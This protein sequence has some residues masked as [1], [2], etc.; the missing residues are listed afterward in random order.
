MKADMTPPALKAMIDP[1]HLLKAIE[2]SVSHSSDTSHGTT[3]L[4][5]E[6]YSI[7]VRRKKGLCWLIECKPRPAEREA[8]GPKRREPRGLRWQKRQEKP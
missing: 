2:N 1:E 5:F 7:I 6:R 3:G 8:P 4:H